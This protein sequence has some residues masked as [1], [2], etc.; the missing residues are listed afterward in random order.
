MS[1]SVL[2]IFLDILVLVFLGITIFYAIRLTESLNAF[3]KSR[4]DFD[5]VMRALS[6]NITDAQRGIEN[7]KTMTKESSKTISDSRRMAQELQSINQE[8]LALI[9]RLESAASGKLLAEALDDPAAFDIF[10]G[11]GE[12]E[13][14][15]IYDSDYEEKPAKKEEAPSSFQSQAERDLYDA[16]QR[17]RKSSGRGAV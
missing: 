6:K 1:G 17:N 11:G 16:L 13:A 10:D 7:L 12:E 5:N 3:R 2:S 14:F 15:S 4:Q 9:N 8:S